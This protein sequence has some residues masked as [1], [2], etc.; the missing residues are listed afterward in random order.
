M[1]PSPRTSATEGF[2][3][4]LGRKTGPD[5]DWEIQMGELEFS[6][7]AQQ[8]V[9][10]VLIWIGFGTLAGL[11]AK[12]ILPGRDPNGPIGTVL[13][14]VFG[15]TI[16]LAILSKLVTFSGTN[17][18]MNPISPMGMIAAVAGAFATLVIYRVAIACIMIE[19][20]EEPDDS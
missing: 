10:V 13:L 20:N 16:G 9:N 17:N 4:Y 14:G 12:M 5:E 18:P 7:T 8:W 1:R 11:A 15:S 3:Q 2:F 19:R 6:Q